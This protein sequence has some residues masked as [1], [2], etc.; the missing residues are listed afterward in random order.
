MR[1]LQEKIQR[2]ENIRLQQEQAQQQKIQTT[3]SLGSTLI[4]ASMGRKIARYSARSASDVM[5][6]I[7][8]H[9]C[10]HFIIKNKIL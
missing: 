7:F 1:S 5:R 8:I 6:G 10:L 2:T 3:F 9:Y 4:G